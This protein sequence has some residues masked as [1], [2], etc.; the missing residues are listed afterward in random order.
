MVSNEPLDDALNRSSV[1]VEQILPRAE[2]SLD[3]RDFYATDS[4]ILD[5]IFDSGQE[6]TDEFLDCIDPGVQ[7]DDQVESSVE[8]HVWFSHW[9]FTSQANWCETLLGTSGPTAPVFAFSTPGL[10]SIFTDC[11]ALIVSA[12]VAPSATDDACGFTPPPRWT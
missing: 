4:P 10:P 12:D 8:Y 9:A 7:V 5:E 3:P 2:H 11:P 6:S 1:E